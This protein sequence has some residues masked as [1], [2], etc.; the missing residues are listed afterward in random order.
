MNIPT[1]KPITI[2]TIAVYATLARTWRFQAKAWKEL[3]NQTEARRCE[4]NAR[5]FESR[6]QDFAWLVEQ[7]PTESI[8]ITRIHPDQIRTH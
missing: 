2:Q 6:I 7:Y 3:H 4:A 8:G 1:I 5:L